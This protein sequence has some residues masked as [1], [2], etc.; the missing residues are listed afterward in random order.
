[1]PAACIQP[2]AVLNCWSE[3]KTLKRRLMRCSDGIIGHTEPPCGD[4]VLAD[5]SST[6]GDRRP[7]RSGALP[8]G[9]PD[10]PISVIILCVSLLLMSI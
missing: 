4:Y 1:M 9:G 6:N 10:V 8:V 7:A 2:S 3:P 5:T